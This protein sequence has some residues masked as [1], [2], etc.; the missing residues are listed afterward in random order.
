LALP[1]FG[2]KCLVDLLTSLESHIPVTHK[3]NAE[4]IAAARRLER[5]GNSSRIRTD[6]PRFG[7][8]IQSLGFRGK[9]LRQ[10]AGK[11]ANSPTCPIAPTFYLRRLKDLHSD[12]CA[13]RQLRLEDELRSL[14]SCEPNERNCEMSVVFLG[15]DG[16]GSKTLEEVGNRYGIT[17]ERVRQITRRH[18]VWLS[19]RT[20]F[21]PILDRVLETIAKE[22]PRRVEE[23]ETLLADKGLSRKPFRL[24]GIICAAEIAQKELPFVI[25]EIDGQRYAFPPDQ[26]ELLK[27]IVQIAEKSVSHWGATTLEDVAAQVSER[28]NT[29][30]ASNTVARVLRPLSGFAWLD[31]A[32]GWFWLKT[33]GRNALLNQISKVLCVCN[34]LHVT[35]LRAGVSRHHRR[36]GFA[37]PQ[38]VLLALCNQ[39]GGYRVDRSF[40]AADPPLK[41][42]EVL[43]ESE[44][45]IVQVLKEFGPAIERQKLKDLCVTR[46]LRSETVEIYMTYSPVLA[47]YA[48]GVYG[49]RGAEVLPSVAESLVVGRRKTRVMSDY[50]WTPDGRIFTSYKLS[51]GSLSNGIVSAPSRM[52]Q[53]LQGSYQ[54]TTIDGQPIGQLVVK[55]SQTWGLGPLFRRRGGDLG[56]TLQIIYDLKSKLATAELG[57]ADQGD[58]E[59]AAGGPILGA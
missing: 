33:T 36:E 51:K 56:D 57:E 50:G 14:I 19:G 3:N 39:A 18:L 26:A 47:R 22:I 6:D 59:A 24:D 23:L 35:E 2:S 38:R 1:H 52:A 16:S 48:P 42:E 15:W 40:I 4:I 53:Y 11:A 31:E 41:F 46:G 49:L 55:G 30:V 13:C 34:R 20:P 5:S 7:A 8:T 29:P 27:L 37:P 12:L 45:T 9:E 32:S 10:I 28:V 21:L 54:L 25:K 44:K 17:R 43:A 58:A